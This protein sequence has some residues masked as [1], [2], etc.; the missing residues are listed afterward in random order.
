[1]SRAQ[2]YAAVYTAIA[3]YGVTSFAFWD[4]GCQ[5]SSSTY[6]VSPLTPAVWSVVSQHGVAAHVPWPYTPAPCQAS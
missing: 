3:R 1:M 5:L 2:F 6:E 4:L